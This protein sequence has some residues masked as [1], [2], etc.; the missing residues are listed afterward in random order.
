MD[1]TIQ[2]KFRG[3][4]T[5]MKFYRFDPKRLAAPVNHN[6]IV[7]SDLPGLIDRVGP[8]DCIV[9]AGWNISA[10]VGYVEA[11]GAVLSVSKDRT[12]A[13]V[14]WRQAD[15]MLRPNPGGRQFWQK[16]KGW[17]AFAPEV[18]RRY[19][20]NDL[21]AEYFPDL[22]GFDFPA[23]PPPAPRGL[24]PSA[25]PTGGYVY[26]I[27][28]PLGFKIG[29]TVNL[30]SRTRLFEVKLPFQISIEHY[31]WFDDYTH[32]ERSF[33]IS[34]HA[35]RLEGEWFELSAADLVEI[36]KLGRSVPVAGL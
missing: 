6:T 21:Y 22:N 14:H 28:S 8:K 16:E 2:L 1:L 32:A 23:P 30:K 10:Q 4:G 24:R 3:K 9:L 7:E 27:R 13:K 20:L 35:K 33:H 15:L 29:K 25:S 26:V 18:V 34:Y 36:K 11:F 31:A 12:T 19:A 17:F 5:K